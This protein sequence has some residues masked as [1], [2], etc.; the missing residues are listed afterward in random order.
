MGFALQEH[1]REKIALKLWSKNIVAPF[2]FL[3]WSLNSTWRR[4]MKSPGAST[5]ATISLFRKVI[6]LGR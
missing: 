6:A 1:V 5:P 4:D 2:L 3:P